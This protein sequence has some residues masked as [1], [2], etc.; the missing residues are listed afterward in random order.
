[1]DVTFIL[2]HVTEIIASAESKLQ[3][4]H[5]AFLTLRGCPADNV[6]HVVLLFPCEILNV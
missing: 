6:T 3:S 5:A 2:S 4:L 1:M